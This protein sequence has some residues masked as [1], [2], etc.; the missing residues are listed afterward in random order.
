MEIFWLIRTTLLISGSVNSD[1]YLAAERW[2]K[3]VETE[4]HPLISQSG[5]RKVPDKP[6]V[7]VAILDT[8]YDPD[9]PVSK[10]WI[11]RNKKYRDFTTTNLI[12]PPCDECGHG[13]HGLALV[14]R[15]ACHTD[16]YIARVGRK[17]HELNERAVVEVGYHGIYRYYR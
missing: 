1:G 15:C 4:L 5:K 8:G 3:D 10:L 12:A 17:I 11:P 2:L 9:N 13:T 7:K 14:H 16:F 6:R